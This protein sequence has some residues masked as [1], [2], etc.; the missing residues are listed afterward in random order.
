VAC[1]RAKAEL[2][3]TKTVWIK[4]FEGRMLSI[5]MPI[6]SSEKSEFSLAAAHTYS[7]GEKKFILKPLAAGNYEL[8]E[9]K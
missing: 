3:C 8:T 2:D 1:R 9:I 4:E 5:G 6:P 7:G